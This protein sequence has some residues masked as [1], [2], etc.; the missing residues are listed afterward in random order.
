[1]SPKENTI[2]IIPPKLIPGILENKQEEVRLEIMTEIVKIVRGASE[3]LLLPNFMKEQEIDPN[4]VY[5]LE[6]D[7]SNIDGLKRALD[8]VLDK[9][10]LE[11]SDKH[12][13]AVRIVET[14]KTS[15]R[16]DLGS[17]QSADEIESRV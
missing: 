4:E 14:P 11:V 6:I 1:M 8:I 5:D 10:D 9:Y 15:A 2:P 17:Y 13:D 16:D 12:T 7:P 3:Q